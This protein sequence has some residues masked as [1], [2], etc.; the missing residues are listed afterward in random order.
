MG[1]SSDGMEREDEGQGPEWSVDERHRKERDHDTE[2]S[3]SSSKESIKRV[4]VGSKSSD[5]LEWKV[6]MV[7][8]E[9]TGPHLDTIR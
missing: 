2:S 7:F 8:D 1:V 6:V 4:K 5:V 3:G 9:T